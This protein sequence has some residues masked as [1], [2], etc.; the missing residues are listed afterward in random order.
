[1][2]SLHPHFIRKTRVSK[3]LSPSNNLL[4]WF[5]FS[6][7]SSGVIVMIIFSRGDKECHQT[8]SRTRK[9]RRDFRSKMDLRTKPATQ[10]GLPLVKRTILGLFSVEPFSFPCQCLENY[11]LLLLLLYGQ[12]LQ[13]LCSWL[14]FSPHPYMAYILYPD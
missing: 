1:M 11:S 6:C 13:P 7:V 14:P 12:P 2:A 4:F 10:Q 3:L 9:N 8:L 5:S